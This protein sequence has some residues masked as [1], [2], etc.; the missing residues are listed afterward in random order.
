MQSQV[1]PKTVADEDVN[2][3]MF[4]VVR[5]LKNSQAKHVRFE[6]LSESVSGLPTEERRHH[7]TWPNKIQS[8]GLQ[9]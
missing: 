5:N 7:Q 6:V 8:Q 3:K 9:I 1:E 4:I 2:N